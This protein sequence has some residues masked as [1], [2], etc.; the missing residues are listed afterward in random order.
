MKVS[1][2]ISGAEISALAWE[3]IVLAANHEVKPSVPEICGA[4]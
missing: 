2:W 1:Q 4:P 3:I